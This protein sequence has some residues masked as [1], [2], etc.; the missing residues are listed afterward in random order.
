HA[1][2]IFDGIFEGL[3]SESD[4]VIERGVMREIVSHRDDLH[5]GMVIDA[6]DDI[7]MPGLIDVD[8]RLDQ[9]YGGAFG[10]AFLAYGITSV[11][12]PAI[13]PYAALEQ[14]ESF[15]AGRRPGPR[16]FVAGDPFDGMRVYERGGVSIAS[17]DQLTR[18]LDRARTLDVDFFSTNVRLPDRYQRQITEFAHKIGK[19]VLSQDLYPGVAYGVDGVAHLR[20]RRAYADVIDLIAKSG[21]ALTPTIGVQGAFTAR[22]TGDRSLLFDRRFSLYPLPLVSALTDMATARKQPA[23]DAA[24]KPLESTLVS[25]YGAG[26]RILA[27]SDA[28]AVPYG[29]GL[30]VE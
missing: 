6:R 17:D 13:N 12:I 7:V 3:R 4:I 1:G 9:D 15:G 19:P 2:H 23:L 28:P 11:R 21:M 18:E 22:V 10:R 14:R 5:S 26:G 30:H 8:A 24:L 20:T 27:G 16:V 29:F 25:I